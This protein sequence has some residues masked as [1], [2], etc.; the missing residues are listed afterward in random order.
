MGLMPYGEQWKLHH[1]LI[2]SLIN[3]SMAQHYQYL[4]DIES[5]QVMFDM[6]DSKSDNWLKIFHR[7]TS[8]LA[9]T[10]AYG[11]RINTID[12]KRLEEIDSVLANLSGTISSINTLLVEIFPIFNWLPRPL[13]PWKENAEKAH[14]K[15]TAVFEG[16]FTRAQDTRTWNWSKEALKLNSDRALSTGE[17]VHAIGLLYEASTT[18][19]KILGYFVMASL[20]YSAAVSRAQEELDTVIGNNRLPIFED[21]TNLPFINAFVTEVLRWRPIAPLGIP[22][23]NLWDTTFLR[24]QQ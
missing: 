8:S 6:L 20:L 15:V 5:K 24:V 12:N 18:T 14:D 1:R 16:Y 2:V 11:K 19:N 17:L 7:Y 10:L 21:T 13:A 22:H 9:F 3:A 4:Q 23:A